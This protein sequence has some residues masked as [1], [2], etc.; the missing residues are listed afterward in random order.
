MSL[1]Q[2]FNQFLG[3]QPGDAKSASEKGSSGLSGLAGSVPGGLAGGLAAGG[4]L[5]VLAG[6]K[7][8]R[9]SVGKFAGGAAAIGGTA[10]L[11]AL[12]FKAYQNWQAGAAADGTQNTV[13]PPVET[14]A[15]ERFNPEENL[16]AD[17]QQFQLSLVK[18]MI[19]AA[20]ADGHIDGDEQQAVF[21]AVNK[22]QL[23]AEDKSLVFDTLQSPPSITTIAGY[24]DGIE[25]ASEIY[26]VSRMAID[27]D[28]PAEKA[29]LQ[30]LADQMSLP[31][32]LVTHLENQIGSA[33]SRAA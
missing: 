7:K 10:A 15:L 8:I 19:A 16:A 5:G 28:H 25:Q 20:N 22:M 14:P 29:Y 32:D 1:N 11:G 4:L 24:A 30:G 26:L 18:A 3:G 21:D 27:P 6:N 23:D 31:E 12:A 2:L 13:A 17:G 33:Q 9:K